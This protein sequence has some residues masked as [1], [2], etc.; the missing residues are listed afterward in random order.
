MKLIEKLEKA[1]GKDERE[2]EKLLEYNTMGSI[3]RL[4]E[5]GVEELGD[6]EISELLQKI[7]SE[8]EKKRTAILEGEVISQENS[9]E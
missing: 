9:N 4:L 8:F 2:I 5:E 7:I 1:F 3:F 6:K